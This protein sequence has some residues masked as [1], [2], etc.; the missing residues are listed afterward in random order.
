M[1]LDATHIN[2][3]QLLVA[4]LTAATCA[5]GVYLLHVPFH[6]WL[7]E[8]AGM[9]DKNADTAGTVFIVL[10]SFMINNVVSMAIF[11]DVSLG[12]RAVQQQLGQK[13][14]R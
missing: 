2:Q 9:S 12:M 14:I 11:K 8:A 3:R 6:D 7:H 5:A 13:I 10:L 4:L 1:S